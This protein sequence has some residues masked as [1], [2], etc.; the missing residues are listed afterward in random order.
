MEL[1]DQ[2]VSQIENE[3]QV[4]RSLLNCVEREQ[5][6][7]MSA[8]TESLKNCLSE[9]RELL[10]QIK[11][12]EFDRENLL[13]EIRIQSQINEKLTLKDLKSLFPTYDFSSV[14][15]INETLVELIK[16]VQGLNAKNHRLA[17][18]ALRGV[19]GILQNF[20]DTVAGKSTYEKKG[21]MKHSSQVSGSFVKR[22]V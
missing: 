2:L 20:K 10:I 11:V 15:N 13:E 12:I 3:F 8:E 17:Q 16:N 6:F 9:K 1:L 5:T 14:D 18:N 22:Q 7:L 19:E 21:K 4:Y